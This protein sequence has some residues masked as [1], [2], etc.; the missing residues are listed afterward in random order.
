MHPS[1][2]PLAGGEAVRLVKVNKEGSVLHEFVVP[3]AAI[4]R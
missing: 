2:P 4:A 3:N 1:R